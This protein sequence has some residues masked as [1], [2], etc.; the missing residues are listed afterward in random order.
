MAGKC[1]VGGRRQAA[2]YWCFQCS[3]LRTRPGPLLEWGAASRTR[4]E[5]NRET[6]WDTVQWNTRGPLAVKAPWVCLEAQNHMDLRLL[7][8]CPATQIQEWRKQ[9]DEI[10]LWSG[11][12]RQVWWESKRSQ[13]IL[14]IN[15]SDW[16][17]RTWVLGCIGKEIKT[18][19]KKRW[20][21]QKKQKDQRN[22][23]FDEVEMQD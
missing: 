18:K 23:C 22:A 2:F 8:P 17:D 10:I 4:L 11:F 15:S 7:H 20:Y 14:G 9:S 21:F 5:E 19:K 16:S 3:W 12:D 13:V 6:H 1:G